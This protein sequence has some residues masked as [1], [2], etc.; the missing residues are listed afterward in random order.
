MTQKLHIKTWGCQM[1]EYDSSKMADL[2]NS[3]HG[4]ELT[5]IPE[6]AD[7]LLLNT[8]SIREKAQEK[9][10]HQL[11]RWKELKKTNPALVIGVGGCVASQEGEHIRSRAPYV[12]IVFGPQTLHRLPEMINQIRGGKSS[13]VDVSFPEIEKFDRLPEP[14]AEGPTAFVSIME[15]CNK[16]CT[17]CVVPYTRGEEVSRPLD[18]VLFE[19]AQL[20]EQG[21]REVNLLGQNVN[22]YRGPT[23]DGGICSFAEL[24][25]L[26]AA[27]DGIDRVRFTTS[28]P[29]EFTDDIIEVYADTPELV[30]FLHLPVQSG[31]DRILNQMKRGHTALEYKSIIRKLRKVRPD[32]QISSDFIV[33]FPGET[34]QDFEDTMNLI[35]QVNFDMSFSFIY[36]A[37]P[38]TPAADILDDVSEEEKKQRLYV[39]QQR[40]NNQAA[41]F[42]RAMLGTEQRVLVEGPSK[43]DIMELTGRTETNRI[44]NFV[45]TPDMI[46]K[47]VDIKIT[48][49]FTNSLRGD[50]VRTEDQ[51]GLRVVQSP[52][53]VI[54]RTRK[55]DELGVGHYQG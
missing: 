7:V 41:Q 8:C 20:A 51:M 52:Q 16:Y 39:L 36:S 27:I 26:V 12:D 43:K 5:E 18:D 54:N 24:L 10:F 19:I 34:E 15:G 46:G 13:V 22:A 44:V 38:G 47:F 14:R 4:L 48:D 42:S 25:R 53:A 32:I 49:V 28:H 6:E 50:V 29:I 37:R 9:V 11:G 30:S 31:S 23:H 40:I 35:A 45:G 21:V 3:T 2:L 55:E 17:F 1:N 33:G